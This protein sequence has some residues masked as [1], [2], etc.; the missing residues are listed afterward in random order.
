MWTILC[1]NQWQRTSTTISYLIHMTETFIDHDYKLLIEKEI[2]KVYWVEPHYTQV[3]GK[4]SSET[5]CWIALMSIMLKVC[6]NFNPN[7]FPSLCFAVDPGFL[8]RFLLLE[9]STSKGLKDCL[10]LETLWISPGRRS[11]KW[12][13]LCFSD[14]IF[15]PFSMAIFLAESLAGLS[16]LDVFLDILLFGFHASSFWRGMSS[17]SDASEM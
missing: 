16:S 11:F 10:G 13:T 7:N 17:S 4:E 15:R 6:Q 2:E 1:Y 12:F 8:G 9:K 14:A 3:R 5:K